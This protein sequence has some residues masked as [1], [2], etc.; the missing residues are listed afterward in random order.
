M[1]LTARVAEIV[2][3]SIEAMGYELVR[4]QLLGGR[5]PI[6]QIMAER[7]DRA[8]MTVEDCGKLSRTISAL[9]DVDDPVQ[10]SYS[11]E[12]SSPGVDRPLTRLADFE[13]FAGYEARVETSVP[14]VGRKRFRGVLRG[15]EGDAVKLA[16]GKADFVLVPFSTIQ[17]AKLLMSDALIAASGGRG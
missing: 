10:G 8:G 11:L 5:A 4:V 14:V 3:P 2:A 7:G 12:V 17:R 6:L 16:L 15:V 1:D 13:R 9:L